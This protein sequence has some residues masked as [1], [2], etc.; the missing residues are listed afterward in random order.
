M[1]AKG[2]ELLA[3]CSELDS[4]PLIV[5][6]RMM[7]VLAFPLVDT[8]DGLDAELREQLESIAAGVK[9]RSNVARAVSR[10]AI[11]ELCRGRYLTLRVLSFLL[12]RHEN[13]LRQRVLNRLVRERTLELAFPQ[14]PNDPRQAYTAA[15]EATVTDNESQSEAALPAT[16]TVWGALNWIAFKDLRPRSEAA[17]TSDLTSRWGGQDPC[18]VLQALEA[19]ASPQPY[20]ILDPLLMDNPELGGKRYHGLASRVRPE[21]LRCTRRKARQRESRLVTFAELPGMLRTELSEIEEK[22]SRR[23][24]ALTIL[25]DAIRRGEL[26]ALALQGTSGR[27]TGANAIHAKVDPN[28]FL[29]DAVA[30]TSQSTIG[31]NLSHPSGIVNY[32]GPHYHDVQFRSKDV[33]ARWPDPSTH[34]GGLDSNLDADPSSPSTLPHL[35]HKGGAR[36]RYDWDAFWIEA[37]FWMTLNGTDEAR[38]HDLQTHMLN[39]TGEHW[40]E[41]PHESTIREKLKCLYERLRS[42]PG[43]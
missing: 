38:R 35:L 15:L 39:W 4:E 21:I 16:M 27:T 33:L 36:T 31:A 2:S 28:V 22:S 30:L 32:Q 24:D 34:V 1:G 11:S 20:H 13:H 6:G 7:K 5:V 17:E 43:S 19:R 23:A 42:K 10:A 37:M 14:A 29:N 8:L 12:G 41:P 9:G 25:T 40:S 18:L 26:D 3:E